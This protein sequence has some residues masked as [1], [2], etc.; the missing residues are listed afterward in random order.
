MLLLQFLC[1]PCK[2]FTSRKMDRFSRILCAAGAIINS[3]IVPKMKFIRLLDINWNLQSR[4]LK[5]VICLGIELLFD[6]SKVGK[7]ISKEFN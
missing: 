3:R 6:A 7:L 1:E 2:L 4:S 5:N